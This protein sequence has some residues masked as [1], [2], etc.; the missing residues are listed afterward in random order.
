[1]VN[2]ANGKIY[3]IE[4]IDGVGD[5][6]IGSTTKKYLAQRIDR[7]RHDYIGWKLGCPNYTK[8]T[9]FDVF[10][11]YGVDNCHIILLETFPCGSVDELR[12]REAYHIR[13]TP[14]TNKNIPGRTRQQYRADNK[15]KISSE[16]KERVVCACGAALAQH[17]LAR[18]LRTDTHK[19]AIAAIEVPNEVPAVELPATIAGI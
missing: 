10:D 2:Y 13:N 3:K 16:K 9:C 19:S 5:V 7:H 6:Y 15:E 11:K 12:A 17:S 8:T 1:M 18:H 14:C 4:A